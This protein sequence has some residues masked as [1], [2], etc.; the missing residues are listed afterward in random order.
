MVPTIV[1]HEKYTLI[2][3]ENTTSTKWEIDADYYPGFLRALETFSQLF[4]QRLNANNEKELFV[5]DLP[6]VIDDQPDYIW[7][8]LMIDSSRHFQPV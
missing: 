4:Q 5:A 6:I 7:R 1:G 8:G 3:R 2:L